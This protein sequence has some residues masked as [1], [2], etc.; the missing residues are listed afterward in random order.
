MERKWWAILNRAVKECKTPW[1][2][3]AEAS[4][5]IKLAI[6]VVNLTK[7]VGGEFMAYPKSLTELDDPDLDE[8]VQQ[9]IDV[10]HH[11]TGV[12]PEEW[13]KQVAH[14]RDDQ[15]SD[16]P[17]PSDENGSDGAMSPGHTVAADLS[18]DDES[19]KEEGGNTGQVTTEQAAPSS[20]LSSEDRE[21]LLS[22]AKQLWAATG[23]GE[24]ELVAGIANDLRNTAPAAISQTAR[25]KALSIV[26]QCKLVCFGEQEA[27]DTLEIVA[28]IAGVET[29]AVAS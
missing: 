1:K 28:G 19:G 11:V 5:A 27:A 24:Q 3:A 26:K 23:V 4:E 21:W 10:V 9:M 12:D 17:S 16:N 13:K 8:A 22:V 25:A 15:S 20:D 29:A 6:G 7:T 18:P 2:T 14:I